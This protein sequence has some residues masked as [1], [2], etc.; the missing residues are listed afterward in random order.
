MHAAE[1]QLLIFLMLNLIDNMGLRKSIRTLEI[2]WKLTTR[3]K[4]SLEKFI[5]DFLKVKR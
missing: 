4:G 3:S 5:A 1:R 2:E